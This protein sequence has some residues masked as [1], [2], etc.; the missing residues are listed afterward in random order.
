MHVS[1][2]SLHSHIHAISR[3]ILNQPNAVPPSREELKAAVDTC[4][5]IS[6][7]G[8]CKNGPQGPIRDWHLS[9]VT[10]MSEL[11]KSDNSLNNDVYKGTASFNSDISNWDVSGVTNMASM[12]HGAT[13]FNIDVSRWDVSRVNNMARM[14]MGAT[15]FNA[16]ISK[17]DVS[18]VT[19]MENMFHGAKAFTRQL[20]N[21]WVLHAHN[22]NIFAGS[23]GSIVTG[24]YGGNCAYPPVYQSPSKP[25]PR[26]NPVY[27]PP[28]KPKTRDNPVYQPPYRPNPRV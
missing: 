12:F 9:R 11:F 15:L 22:P 1:V 18:S 3:V 24:H 17:W 13:S 4:I 16:D 8:D 6:P 14:F 7:V 2:A 28:S 20:C 26:D 5:N 23:S 25:K 10:D 21:A 27:Q 19:N